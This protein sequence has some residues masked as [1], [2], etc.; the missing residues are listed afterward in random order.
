MRSL[1]SSK[2]Q[3]FVR[4]LFSTIEFGFI[5]VSKLGF[6]PSQKKS[7][8]KSY[9]PISILTPSKSINFEQLS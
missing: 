5:S 1:E 4:A 9:L 3:L 6:D 7:A 8:L 2:L